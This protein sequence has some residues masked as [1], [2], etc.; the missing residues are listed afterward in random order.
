MPAPSL[1]PTYAPNTTT[2]V[3]A[4]GMPGR[5]AKPCFNMARD[6]WC[7]FG[8]KCKF[9]HDPVVLEASRSSRDAAG[10]S[11][12]AQDVSMTNRVD[13]RATMPCNNLE[14]FDSCRGWTVH[15]FILPAPIPSSVERPMYLRMFLLLINKADSLKPGKQN[16]AGVSRTVAVAPGTVVTST[17]SIHTDQWKMDA[18]S[19]GQAS[20]NVF[21]SQQAPTNE[22]SSS[23]QSTRPCFNEQDHDRCIKPSCTFAH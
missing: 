8:D 23:R 10:V 15:T 19:I 12:T 7:K 14:K 5:A 3:T 18:M 13:K 11:A 16:H 4:A 6:G 20:G 21:Q 22:G 17:T 2:N 9:S 1:S